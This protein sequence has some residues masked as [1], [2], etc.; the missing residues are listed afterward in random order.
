L[1]VQSPEFK[2]QS[3][4]KKRKRTENIS[5]AT[6]QMP[7]TTYNSLKTDSQ[8][9]LGQDREMQPYFQSILLW[10]FWRWSSVNCLPRLASNCDPLNLSLPKS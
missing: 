5:L 3:H 10:L 8:R 9:K 1:Q 4:Q 2:T 7:I 6:D